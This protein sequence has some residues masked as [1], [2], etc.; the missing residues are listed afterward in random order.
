MGRA[1]FTRT[2][3]ISFRAGA[4][5]LDNGRWGPDMF[6]PPLIYIGAAVL[7]K[8]AALQDI[9]PIN[10]SVVPLCVDLSFLQAP[11][12]GNGRGARASRP[13]SKN[14]GKKGGGSV[15]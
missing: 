4:V 10:M 6:Q 9:I 8:F 15:M 2:Q 3:H 5:K 1:K 13:Q 12:P 11:L 14:R 7:H